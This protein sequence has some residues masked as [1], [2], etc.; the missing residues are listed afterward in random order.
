MSEGT[1]VALFLAV[2]SACAVDRGPDRPASV[3]TEAAWASGPDGGAWVDC[4]YKFKEPYTGYGCQIYNRVGGSQA[5][6]TFT[7]ARRN[8][9]RFEPVPGP[10]G[11]VAL[12]DLD[13][14]DGE[15][16]LVSFRYRLLPDGWIDYPSG[17]G[18]GKR[19]EYALGER[20]NEVEY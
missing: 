19:I 12:D 7:L 1:A 3:P 10:F 6:G 11:D 9:E 4:E 2:F 14:Y 15:K 16:I 8:G 17:D 20:R 13:A 5:S 18:H